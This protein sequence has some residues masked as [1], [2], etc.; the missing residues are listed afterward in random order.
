MEAQELQ[1]SYVAPKTP[2]DKEETSSTTS[3]GNSAAMT[4][5][6]E[7]QQLCDADPDAERVSL[8]G[9][10]LSQEEAEQA[11]TFLQEHFPRLRHL[12]LRDNDLHELPQDFG[13]RLPKLVALN[14]SNNNFRFRMGALRTLG[15][16]LQHCPCLKSLSLSLS[17]P[18]EEQVLLSMLPRLRILNGTPLPSTRSGS[19]GNPASP[20][21]E[22]LQQYC[23]SP[24][25]KVPFSS[26]IAQIQ[27]KSM[28][29]RTSHPE[30]EPVDSSKRG[31]SGPRRNVK[32]SVRPTE[33]PAS[34][35]DERT[36]WCKLLKVNR[37]QVSKSLKG[38]ATSAQTPPSGSISSAVV[39]TETFLQQLK[40][41]VKAFHECDSL[42]QANSS[43]KAKLFAQLDRHVDML[44]H[45]L[46]RQEPEDGK[47]ELSE[48][49]LQTR[50][51]LLEVC[52]M[53]GSQKV[54]QADAG[55]GNGFGML[56][57]MQKQLRAAT[58]AQQR[59]AQAQIQAQPA[60]TEGATPAQNQQQLKLLL[61]VAEGLES[62][63]VAVQSQLEQETAR[64]ELVEQENLE[65]KRV[66]SGGKGLLKSGPSKST[67]VQS[68]S[69]STTATQ[70]QRRFRRYNSEH[71]G[72]VSSTSDPIEDPQAPEVQT[73]SSTQAAA[74]KVTVSVRNLSLK[75]LVDLIN[76]VYESKAKY[77][78]RA[79]TAGAPRETM[80]Q[81]LYTYLNT[82][83]GLPKLIVDYA[84]AVWKAAEHFARRENDA[85]VFVALLRNRLDEGFLEIKKKL[86]SALVELLR[87][88]FSAKYPVKQGK[89]IAALVQSRTDG[90]LHEEEWRN[91]LTYLYEPQDSATLM[92]LVQQKADKYQAAQVQG[93]K[94]QPN[95][96]PSLSLPFIDFEQVLYGYQL[97]GRLDLLE[98]F[99]RAFEELDT[100]RVGV[101]NRPRFVT[102]TR[103]LAPTKSESAMAMLLETLDPL[104]HDVI[105]FSDAANALLPDIR[106][107]STKANSN[108]APQAKTRKKTT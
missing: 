19:Q 56:L 16:T 102:L 10:H 98:G 45:Q 70:P 31:V 108:S 57:A 15:D 62:D 75:Q 1:T 34:I 32:N 100:E 29:V 52:A 87:A 22:E 2:I 12:D 106:H 49:M 54:A 8:R 89:A 33:Q 43:S 83:F 93:K 86:Q 65:L 11:L 95:E 30:V 38:T 39:P 79:I 90:L 5:M 73:D 107:I 47:I 96:K 27:H 91:L 68:A 55:L 63:L 92:R 23:A 71:N 60:T 3:S 48:A 69:S 46:K 103:R 84:S 66:R 85:A 88:F 36:D 18:A 64:R 67:V 61:D 4:A 81:H 44:A 13:A 41:V 24:L 72:L 7:L 76:C 99:R 80:E 105:T 14:L 78:A 82:R 21:L 53:F 28:E 50:W 58:Q 17:S 25:A 42:G 94:H 51:S 35:S 59:S 9:R 104:N 6:E 101:I 37:S 20:T 77:D 40:A 74:A 26:S 97:Q